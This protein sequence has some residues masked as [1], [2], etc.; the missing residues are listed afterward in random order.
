MS[1]PPPHP[2]DNLLRN[3][4]DFS[5]VH[6]RPL[7]QIFL[8]THLSN[9]A[10]ELARQ[11]TIVIALLAWLPLFLLSAL[12]GHLLGGVAVPFLMDTEVHIR[13]F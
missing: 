13:F 4:P 2:S 5:L 9:D 11:R 1:T 10:M 6:G 12:D 7:F 3:P 8:R